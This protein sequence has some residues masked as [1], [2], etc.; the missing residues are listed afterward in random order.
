MS[1]HQY[2][3]SHSSFFPWT[4][5]LQ[6]AISILCLLT[7]ATFAFQQSHFGTSR[8]LATPR[9]L[10][11]KNHNKVTNT[12]SEENDGTLLFPLRQFQTI[13]AGFAAGV[14]ILS[15]A[16]FADLAIVT[17]PAN[18]EL[19]LSRGAVVIE[20]SAKQGQSLLKTEI[21]SQ[22]LI[23]TLFKNRKEL[24]ASAGRI[25][26]AFQDELKQPVWVEIQKEL[27]NVE[28]DVVPT[29][30][31][32]PPSDISVAIKDIS[33][34]KINLLVNGEIVNIAVEPSF[35]KEE[36]DLIVRIT[37]FKGGKLSAMVEDD[38]TV[39]ATG[40]IRSWLSQFDEFWSFWNAAYP[41][42]FLLNGMEATNGQIVLTG[43]AATEE[44]NAAA[45]KAAIAEKAKLKEK[46]VA[47]E[48]QVSKSEEGGGKEA[49]AA[50]AE[51]AESQGKNDN[52]LKEA[53]SA[54]ASNEETE[55]NGKSSPPDDTKSRRGFRFWKQDE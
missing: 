1:C 8:R 14:T 17:A 43:A 42:K 11:N 31:I 44:A 29:F 9:S 51:G 48:K 18:A 10:F 21:D 41:S 15:S 37:G 2:N 23:K 49:N 5:R 7:G 39:S 12:S 4:M 30:K 55:S 27:G 45:K 53:K 34:G 16:L 50:S 46:K 33:K 24:G 22:S 40:P 25:Q 28:D 32:S 52:A 6:F 36:D 35:S 3:C 26:Q 19:E 20:T 13:A 38:S 47:S 54:G